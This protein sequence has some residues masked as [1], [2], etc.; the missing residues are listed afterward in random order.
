[1]H[2]S[3]AYNQLLSHVNATGREKDGYYPNILEEIYDYE[4]DWAEDIIWKAFHD[5]DIEVVMYLPKL[6]NI[7]GWVHLKK[8]YRIVTYPAI[9]VLDWL[10]LY[11]LVQN[12]KNTWILL[13]PICDPIVNMT[14]LP[15]YIY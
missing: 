3:K 15:Y 13:S 7:M 8:L 11:I 5:G 1:M 9:E 6:K 10:K 12:I 2:H 14:G 4:R